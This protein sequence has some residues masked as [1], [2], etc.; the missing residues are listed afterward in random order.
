MGF[1]RSLLIKFG[2]ADLSSERTPISVMLLDDDR[3]RHRW[4]AKRF[5][6]D[7][8]DIAE[9][10]D[11]AKSFLA[12]SSYDAIFLDHDLLPHRAA[13]D[14]GHQARDGIGWPARRG[15]HAHQ[16]S[17]PDRPGAGGARR[18]IR[19]LGGR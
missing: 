8:L 2:L 5:D 15:R 7:Y 14:I 16:R 11:E 9:N 18:L 10:V 17:P 4:F 19:T 13:H 6:G 3:R 12:T 1:I